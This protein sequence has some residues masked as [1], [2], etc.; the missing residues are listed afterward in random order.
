MDE[1]TKRSRSAREKQARDRPTERALDEV[2][3]FKD[4]ITG[5]GLGK[6][7]AV[8]ARFAETANY[9]HV[10]SPVSEIVSAGVF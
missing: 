9:L 1:G 7:P 8:P 3:P 10:P 5:G 4:G 6:A 2:P